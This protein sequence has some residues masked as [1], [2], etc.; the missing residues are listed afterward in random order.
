MD[1]P[2]ELMLS[3]CNVTATIVATNVQCDCDQEVIVRSLPVGILAEG[4]APISFVQNSPTRFTLHYTAAVIV[5]DTFLVP[6]RVTQ[7]RTRLGGHLAAQSKV[8]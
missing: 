4:A 1:S 6:S 8:F 5:T 2:L 3:D 7:V